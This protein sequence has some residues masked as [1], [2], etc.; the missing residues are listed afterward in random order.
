M[1]PELVFGESHAGMKSALQAKFVAGAANSITPAWKR[2]ID[3]LG[4]LIAL[5][6][7]APAMVGIALLIRLS[8]RGP[9]IFSQLRGG[10]GGVPF[11]I[12]KFRT[13]VI[14]AE[15]RK[16]ELLQRNERN[17]PAFKLR[18]DPR[19]TGIGR[20]LRRSSLDELPQFFNVL[21]GEM[22][23]VG[24]RPLPVEEC[25]ASQDWHLRRLAV[26][27]GITCIWQVSGRD[28]SCFDSWMRQDIEY[29]QRHSLLL[30]ITLLFK[31]I[32]AVLSR[33]GAH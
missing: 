20:L 4:A 1:E 32:P 15:D 8:S 5:V 21:V 30:D 10:Q 6:L 18:N 22:S 31:T 27:P 24:P 25:L 16:Q 17:G 19:V 14:D 13:M 3:I 26:K 23:L 9:V 11:R 2:V 12:Y 7:L 29:I 33:R 28:D